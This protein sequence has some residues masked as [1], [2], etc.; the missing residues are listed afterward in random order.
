MWF[1]SP[2]VF[3][4]FSL[5]ANAALPEFM[6]KQALENIKFI[7]IDGKYTYYQRESGSLNLSTNFSASEVLSNQEG[8]EYILYA[9]SARKKIAIEVIS[10]YHSDFNFIR[11]NDIFLISFG[12]DKAQKAAEG[13]FP[14]LHIDD[15]FLSF[16]MP[17]QRAVVFKNLLANKEYRIVINK[18]KNPY[19]VPN[20]EMVNRDFALYTDINDEG[21]SSLFAISLL[22]NKITPVY[23]A[24]QKATRLEM[25]IVGNDLYAGEFP[26]YDSKSG[27]SIYKIPLYQN[28]NYEKREIIYSTKASDLGNLICT[29]EALYFIKTI[30]NNEELF[31]KTTEVAKLNLKDRKLETMTELRRVLSLVNM[32]GRILVPHMNKYYVLTG[33]SDLKTQE[34]QEEKKK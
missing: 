12:E 9:S 33:S 24:T 29:E 5:S 26:L 32:D 23:Q 14:K 21:Y 3:L 20:M 22:D 6:T 13:I 30:K 1:I 34:L 17:K 10:N 4:V 7:T 2:L 16:Y 31:S 28:K 8:T 15:N 25:C 11:N 18:T 27:S 19:F